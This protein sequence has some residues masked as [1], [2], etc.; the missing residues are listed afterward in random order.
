MKRQKPKGAPAPVLNR[1]LPNDLDL[2]ATILATILNHGEEIA[3]KVFEQIDTHHFYDLEHQAIYNTSLECMREGMHGFMCV[4]TKLKSQNP[5]N[6]SFSV[7]TLMS[8]YGLERA[9]AREIDYLCAT[10]KAIYSKRVAMEMSE[11]LIKDIDTNELNETSNILERVINIA[12]SLTDKSQ[13]QDS[14]A[15][16]MEELYKAQ[17][18]GEHEVSTGVP[19]LD[20]KIGGLYPGELTFIGGRPGMGKTDF[21]I[22]IIDALEKQGK[23]ILFFSVEMPKTSI[24]N[25][26]ALF[27]LSQ[28]GHNITSKELRTPSKEIRELVLE[29]MREIDKRGVLTIVDNINNISNIEL[30][31]KVHNQK[32]DT[33]IILL[34]FIQLTQGDSNLNRNLNRNL[35]LGEISK[36]MA[37]IAKQSKCPFVC[38]SQ[39]KT[40]VD[41]RS[42]KV[43]IGSDLRDS[44]ELVANADCILLLH[45]PEYYNILQD[46]TGESTHNLL[47]IFVSKQ[48]EG[49]TGRVQIYYSPKT[50]TYGSWGENDFNNS[51]VRPINKDP[52]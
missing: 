3:I 44:G 29:E 35:E 48:R 9:K 21:I 2:E 33:K 45:R 14:F 31:C 22:N 50:K 8:V 32:Y 19:K 30:Y 20:E 13:T 47:N 25:R 24:L 49:A 18:N 52:F 43:P 7:K 11:V 4:A 41:D 6:K 17:D 51:Y 34:D 46:E 39:L 16:L 10:L 42:D 40:T 12:D 23:S 36:K 37:W 28:K 38:L 15:E 1:A 5:D 26:I 27:R